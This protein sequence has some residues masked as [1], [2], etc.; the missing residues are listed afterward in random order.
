[1]SIFILVCVSAHG[2]VAPLEGG[3]SLAPRASAS[4]EEKDQAYI[5]A[6]IKV[7]EAAKKYLGVQYRYGG[8]TAA[9]LD[10][11]GLIGISFREALG[12]SPPRSASGL[13]TWAIRIPLE[14]AQPGDL[15]FFRTG[16]NSSITH[17]ALYLGSR[18]FIHSASAGA[19]TGVIYS[20]L[21]EQY[22]TST[23]AGAGRVFPEAA[24][25]TIESN[26]TNVTL[27][28]VNV[29]E[30]SYATTQVRVNAPSTEQNNKNERFHT[31]IAIAPT[32]GTFIPDGNL[33][34][35]FTSQFFLFADTQLF[36]SSMVFGLEFR[37][38]YDGALGVFRLP[39]TLS[40]GPSEK[41]RVFAGPVL[42]L[43]SASLSTED[44]MRNYRGGTSW[45]G[46]MGITAAP[47]NFKT[48]VGA[49]SPY[50]ELTWQSY[51]SDN[52]DFHPAAD[53]SASFRFSTGLRWMIPFN[54]IFR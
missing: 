29:T 4:Q 31:G 7:I 12:V 15:L 37:P 53:L 48:T 1:V 18:S 44:G 26:T 20:S 43:G 38:E 24:P 3:Y 33:F 36:G 54:Q 27:A 41:F 13:Y 21:D 9:G 39:L 19:N 45:L 49:F 34:R 46:T 2:L 6:R 16:T 52:N 22:W 23:F 5:D 11:S 28:S 32:W 8:T 10:C 25:F 40:W 50:F 30:E 35:G 14:S 17:V 47:Y 42:S 51:F